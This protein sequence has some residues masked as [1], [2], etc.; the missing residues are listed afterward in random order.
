LSYCLLF[1]FILFCPELIS[2]IDFTEEG[3]STHTHKNDNLPCIIF[4]LLPFVIFS[5]QFSHRFQIC[6]HFSHQFSLPKDLLKWNYS[7]LLQIHSSNEQRMAMLTWLLLKF[8][9]KSCRHFEFDFRYWCWTWRGILSLGE[10]QYLK[11]K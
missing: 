7:A 11:C 8:K 4:Q 3:C 2:K 9:T 5:H 1:L 10:R 6:I